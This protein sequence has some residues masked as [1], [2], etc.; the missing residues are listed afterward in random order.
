MR[1]GGAGPTYVSIHPSDVICS[2]R[3]TSAAPWRSCRFC[4]TAGWA[5]RRDVKVDAGTIGPT[6]ATH[7]PAGSFAIS[8]HDRTHAHM[9]QADPSGTF[10]LH[11]DLGLDE[12]FVWKFDAAARR[13]DRRTILR[14]SSLPP[15]DG[16]RHFH[17]HPNGRWFYSIQEEG[18][19]VV[20]FDYDA[21]TRAADRTADDL[22]VAAGLCWQQLLLRRFSCQP[23]ADS[24]TPATACTTASASSRSAQDGRL[25]Y[26]GEEWTRGNYPRSFT[27]DPSGQF[28]YC[29]NQRADAVTVFRVDKTTGALAFTRPLRARRQSIDGRIRRSRLARPCEA[30]A[31]LARFL[32]TW[33]IRARI[34]R[35]VTP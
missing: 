1:S 28:L 30:A 23:T 15:G 6:K 12:I 13:A 9:I 26:V 32:S 18:S 27:F 3:T 31:R 24:C 10:V 16:P 11:V 17:F 22:H 21:A 2:W 25:T 29:C 34:Y 35:I 20:L 33:A 7:A 8:G 4:R 5:N 19:T 14:P